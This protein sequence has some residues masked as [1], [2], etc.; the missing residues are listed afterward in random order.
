[1]TDIYLP[2]GSYAFPCV[3]ADY[4]PHKLARYADNRLIGALRFPDKRKALKA[5]L[6]NLPTFDVSQRELDRPMRRLLV[7][8]LGRFFLGLDRTAELSENVHGNILEGYVGREPHTASANARLRQLYEAQKTGEFCALGSN[9]NTAQFSCALIGTPGV[10]KSAALARVAE[11]YPPLIHHPE[12]DL[13]QI[14]VLSIEMAYNGMSQG[15]LAHAIIRAIAKRFPPG[16]YERLYLKSRANSEQLLLAAFALMHVHAVGALFVDEA[17]NRDYN[18]ETDEDP[19]EI[20]RVRKYKVSQSPLITLLITAS[21][22]MQVPLLMSGTA[23]LRDV[24]GK[25]L[26]KV[27]RMVGEG[28]RPWGPLSVVP[29]RTSPHSDYDLFMNVL[30]AYNWLQNPPAYPEMRSLFHYYT[31]GIPDFIVKLFKAVQWRALEDGLETFDAALVHQVANEELGAITRI[32]RKMHKARTD[33]AARAEL[34]MVADIAAEF[35]LSPLAENFERVGSS[36]EEAVR[37]AAEAP[38]EYASTFTAKPTKEP[39]RKSGPAKRDFEQ[40]PVANWTEVGK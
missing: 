15:T 28:M 22:R 25:R 3:R 9:S 2:G 5:A 27:R 30:W 4:V 23:E 33:L 35:G 19:E 1:M 32:T 29:S 12:L 13:W 16:D 7:K 34:S 18:A 11:L 40:P 24:M 10:G 14:P 6:T 17:Q 26:S 8:Q 36:L 31:F 21:N 20:S 39:K 38:K 37:E